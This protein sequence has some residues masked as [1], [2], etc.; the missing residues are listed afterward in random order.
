VEGWVGERDSVQQ[1]LDPQKRELADLED[2]GTSSVQTG[3]MFWT[4]DRQL[5][6]CLDL[7]W[8]FGCRPKGSGS[9]VYL[10]VVYL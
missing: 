3:D 10:P 5:A 1:V 9:A 4:R 6:V 2:V 7:A 8:W